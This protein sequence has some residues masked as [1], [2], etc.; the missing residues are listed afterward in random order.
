MVEHSP[1]T[2]MQRFSTRLGISQTRVWRTLHGDGLFP[3]PPPKCVQNLCPGDSAM[4]LEF[5]HWL[6][7]HHQLLPLILFTDEATFTH[8]GINNTHNSHWWSHDNPHSTVETNF[9]CHFA[10][11][12]CCSMID[13]MLIGPIILDDCMTGHDYLDFLKMDY[14]KI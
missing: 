9:E 6:H 11:S 5:C 12:V 1:S 8:N 3:I 2:G 4:G 14:Q 7:T 10:L 13:D